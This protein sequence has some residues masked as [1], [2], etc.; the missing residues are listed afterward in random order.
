[1]IDP[2][3]ESC[4]FARGDMFSMFKR[5]LLLVGGCCDMHS[6]LPLIFSFV[7]C[8]LIYLLLSQEESGICLDE[9]ILLRKLL[10][11]I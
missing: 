11:D 8:I 10:G 4:A 6:D 1:M 3:P 9:S 7:S 2:L 5:S